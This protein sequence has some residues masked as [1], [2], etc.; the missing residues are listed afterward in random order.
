MTDRD[1][2]GPVRSGLPATSREERVSLG[3]YQE[4]VG[5][6]VAIQRT[7]TSTILELSSG[8]IEF[9]ASSDEADI[10]QRLLAG[11]EGEQV[12]ILRTPSEDTPLRIRL[13]GGE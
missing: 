11:R 6:V 1:S 7:D 2:I 8:T 3:P 12:A 10:C 13:M 4:L 5:T 9:Q